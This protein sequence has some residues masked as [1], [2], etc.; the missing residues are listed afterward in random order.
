MNGI[1][2]RELRSLYNL[3][4]CIATTVILLVS[5]TTSAADATQYVRYT[6]GVTI[7]YGILDGDKVHE[8]DG[9]LFS[10][11]EPTGRSHSLSKVFLLLPVDPEKVTHVV[12]VAGNTSWR[13]DSGRPR[14]TVLHPRWFTKSPTSLNTWDGDIEI[15]PE[16]E[17]LDWEGELVL[18]IGKK[19]RHISVEDA[20]DHIFGVAVGN[21]VSE[22]TWYSEGMRMVEGSNWPRSD[23]NIPTKMLSKSPDTWAVLGKSIV[24][25]V[26][27]SDLRVTIKQNDVL[28]GDGRTSNMINS[29]ARLVSYLSRYITLLPGDLIYTGTVPSTDANPGRMVAGDVVEI[30][31]ES[32][33]LV[34]NKVVEVTEPFPLKPL[35][36]SSAGD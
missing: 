26:D 30:E 2:L 36:E 21:D 24:T 29:P 32:V 22:N 17:N 12:G 5:H 23:T 8:L 15:Y 25:G 9:D 14:P 16:A 27:Y 28:V 19:G 6:D 34:R 20:P 3:A 10:N 35:D 1:L 13:A 4:A 33:G 7:S 31:I 11:P 18:V